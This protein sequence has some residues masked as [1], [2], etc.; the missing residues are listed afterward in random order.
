MQTA[1]DLLI[2]YARDHR[3]RRNIASH[4]VGIPMVVFAVGVLLARVRFGIAGVELTLASLGAFL[5]ALWYLARPGPLALTL[6]V[7]AAV[8]AVVALAHPMAQ[9]GSTS[10]WLA[11]SLG[12]FLLGCSIQWIG[13]F[14]EGKRR[15]ALVHDLVS[16]WAGPLF[17]TAQ[18]LFMLGW[19]KPLLAEMERRAGPAVLRDLAR[20]A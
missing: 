1:T 10:G 5:L 11:W 6:G 14:Y 2:R 12:L 13:H 19:N 17:L 8:G 16:P 18:A 4:F 15:A 7:S 20:I 9:L 3:D